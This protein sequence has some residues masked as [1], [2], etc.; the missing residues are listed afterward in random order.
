MS[1][2]KSESGHNTYAN[3]AGRL[4]QHDLRA[5][6]LD[7]L[8]VLTGCR[9]A[10]SGGFPDGKRPDVLRANLSRGILFIGEAKHSESPGCSATQARLFEYLRWMSI[11]VSERSRTGIFA[12][13]FG[14]KEHT[15]GWIETISNLGLEARLTFEESGVETFGPEII[16]VWFV[17]G[18]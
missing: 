8:A 2:V 9:E 17:L 12:I 10:L 1:Y 16:V 7:E 14:R 5:Q 15:Q 13:C 6:F 4:A 11:H 18:R 3:A